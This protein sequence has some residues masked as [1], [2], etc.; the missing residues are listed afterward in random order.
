MYSD[1]GKI[2]GHGLSRDDDKVDLKSHF[3]LSVETREDVDRWEKELRE[4]GV[5]I[6]GNV[7]DWP[8]G[9]GKSLYFADPDG[10]VGEL[11]SRGIWPHY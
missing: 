8:A 9:G 10:H 11:A 7:N 3:A 1:G 6:T 4:K 2:P 5:E